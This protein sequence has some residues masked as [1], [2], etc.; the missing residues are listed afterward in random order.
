LDLN[1]GDFQ[2]LDV[3]ANM[4]LKSSTFVRSLQMHLYR[5]NINLKI[6]IPYSLPLPYWAEEI[7][8]VGESTTRGGRRGAKAMPLPV[9]EGGRRNASKS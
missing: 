8:L 5:S 4:L 6:D 9:W 1:F 7:R 2:L 3:I